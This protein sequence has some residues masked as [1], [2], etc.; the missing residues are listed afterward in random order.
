MEFECS[1]HEEGHR[2]K[3]EMM[4]FPGK[5]ALG[6]IRK[7]HVWI[8]QYQITVHKLLFAAQVGAVY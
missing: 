6:K 3:H 8:P 5:T 1:H 7:V 4:D 2:L